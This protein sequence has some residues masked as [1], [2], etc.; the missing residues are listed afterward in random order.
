[1]FIGIKN[2]T[3]MLGSKFLSLTLLLLIVLTSEAQETPYID[4]QLIVQLAPGYKPDEVLKDFQQLNGQF[5]GLRSAQILSDSQGIYLFSFADEEVDASLLKA[6]I[7][8][9]YAVLFAQFNHLISER[10]LPNDPSIATQW[11]HVDGSDN[12][13][14]SDLAWDITTGGFTANGDEIVVCVIEGGGSNYNHNDLIANHWVNSSE[15]AGNGIDDDSNGY[16]DDFN[17]WNV[18]NGN[19]NIS[20]G[21]HGTAVS[22][23]IGARGN[24]S[25]GGA[26]VNWNVRI[27]QVQMGGIS[28]ANVIAAYEYAYDMRNLYNTSNGAQGA[29]VVATNA[30]WGIDNA[31]PANYPAWCAMYEA[32][33]QIGVLNCGATANNNVNIDV[34]GDMPT[35]C[36]SDY[37]ISVTA[38]NSSDVRTFSGYGV[39]TIDLGAPG[40][41]VYL[42]SGSSNY[43]FTSGTSFASP[44]VAG[45]IAL[46]YSAPC[47]DLAD[48]ALAN[49]ELAATLV[50]QYLFDGVDPVAN[51]AAEVATGG[52]LNVRNSIDLLLNNCGPIEPCQ[53]VS[54][55]YNVSCVYDEISDSVVPLISLDFEMSQNYCQVEDICYRAAGDANFTCIN[56]PSQG[57]IVNNNNSVFD[58][59]GLEANTEYEFYYSTSDYTDLTITF[60]T[61][62]C[63]ALLAGCLDPAALNYDLNADI[64]NN[65]C[66]YP[67]VD[68]ELNILTDCWGEEVSWQILDNNNNVVA[69]VLPNSYGD[70]ITYTWNGCLSDA[71]YTFRISDSFG[72]GLAGAMY[73]GCGLNGN[74]N[75]TDMYGNVLVQMGNPNYGSEASHVFCVELIIIEG[76]TNPSACNYNP[77]ANMNDGS[78]TYPGCTDLI[79][80]NYNAA[81]GCEDGSCTY[82]CNDCPGDFDADN[83]VNT[84]DLLFLLSEYGCT[85]ACF[86]DMN[87]D[88]EV[89]T[90]DLLSFLTYFGADCN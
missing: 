57:I 82:N 19:G 63:S 2:I 23:M 39:N 9:H 59:L 38:T 29:F 75:M 20:A 61:D 71:C 8:A 58:L 33:G 87:G 43:S 48:L 86:A 24:N 25:I 15:I 89:N 85:V 60:T 36:S 41:S 28:E 56:L 54:L 77:D 18:A 27:M 78:C 50:R 45:A 17:G 67:C 12:D 3:F 10:I 76:C 55:N 44:C 31:N 64:D 11:H 30:S 70:Q 37:M 34:V 7:N 42:P 69:S 6:R 65:L 26:G 72:D 14:D 16:V 1:M 90:N 35:A 40:E 53:H 83:F 62:N 84:N 51:L 13:I 22:G 80:C 73:G 4:G 66:I 47:S 88:S 52:R 21:G 79:A 74:Y 68:V 5:V 32:L 49:P 46:M 81:A